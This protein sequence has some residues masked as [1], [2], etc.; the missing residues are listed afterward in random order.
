MHL[1]RAAGPSLDAL[2]LREFDHL[3]E[4][5]LQ[6]CVGELDSLSLEQAAIGV[7]CGGLGLRR[8]SSLAIP[9]FVASRTETRWVVAYLNAH[10]AELGLAPPDLQ[11]AFDSR[12]KAALDSF[13]ST[14]LPPFAEQAVALVREAGSLRRTPK[15]ALTQR[16][17]AQRSML[18]GDGLILPAGGEDPEFDPGSL[19]SSLASLSDS[20]VCDSLLTRLRGPCLLDR[21]RH[22][23]ELRGASV[24]HDWLWALSDAHGARVPAAEWCTAV[25]IRLGASLAGPG[26]VCPACGVELGPCTCTHGLLCAQSEATRG[27]FA[28][29]D[30]VLPLCHL[31]DP[32]AT[33]E[34][35]GLVPSRPLLRPA[36]ILSS[37]P[38]PGRLAA[39][40]VGVVS[41]DSA[42]AG[43][44]CCEA[45]WRRKK[46]TYQPFAHEF[47]AVYI[48]L[49]W[50]AF[51]REHADT[52][53]VLET[54]ARAA[55]RRR[56]LAD[57][58]P[59]LRRARCAIGVA[60]VCRAVRMTHAVL[61]RD[62]GE[63]A[64]LAAASGPEERLVTLVHGEADVPCSPT[65]GGEGVGG[66]ALGHGGLGGERDGPADL[67]PQGA[68]GLQG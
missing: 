10:L 53:A 39:L 26:S 4:C 14:L 57:H 6:R 45:M 19:Q 35:P 33:C 36:D 25:R 15:L 68:L 55:A 24:N 61:R 59:L 34:S 13:L 1:L 49:V 48:P 23:E 46:K 43:G 66:G 60:L 9:A 52:S 50:S 16:P 22:L 20:Q 41:P 40:D 28:V 54:L 62:E 29:R 44:D 12:T 32:H 18:T 5:S 37:A 17:R 3:V 7:S 42:S 51:G 11:A 56:G 65:S 67:L 8:A 2:A 58:R 47:L 63:E 30:A 38:L 27:H 21:C 31:A 64:H